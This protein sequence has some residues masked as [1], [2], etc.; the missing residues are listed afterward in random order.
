[1]SPISSGHSWE[2]TGRGGPDFLSM[3]SKEIKAAWG[4]PSV[5]GSTASDDQNCN[6]DVLETKV[7]FKKV[8]EPLNM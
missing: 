8:D 4:S 7:M 2:C 6:L 5:L 3:R 1:M